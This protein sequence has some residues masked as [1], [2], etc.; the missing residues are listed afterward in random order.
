MTRIRCCCGTDTSP[1][2]K[3]HLQETPHHLKIRHTPPAQFPGPARAVSILEQA[4]WAF[5]VAE[6]ALEFEHRL[7]VVGA[8]LVRP[9][10]SPRVQF[11]LRGR[12]E[13]ISSAGYIIRL[14]GLQMTRMTIAP[15]SLAESAETKTALVPW[16]HVLTVATSAQDMTE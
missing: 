13:R 12:L 7:P 2:V 15:G 1:T 3:A 16:L 11:T 6:S 10:R 5:T 4:C 8:V 14:Q 9:T